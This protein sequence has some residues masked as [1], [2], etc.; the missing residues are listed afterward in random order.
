MAAVAAQELRRLAWQPAAEPVAE[1]STAMLKEETVASYR[2]LEAY[3]TWLL[4]LCC[5]VFR[6]MIVPDRR[7][8]G[9][10]EA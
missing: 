6:L 9:L 8:L 4:A 10:R 3:V 1:Q 2:M 7:E 5:Q